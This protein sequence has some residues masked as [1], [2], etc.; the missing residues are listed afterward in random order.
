MSKRITTSISAF[1]EQMTELGDGIEFEEIYT[2]PESGEVREESFLVPNP[3]LTEKF[4][5][6]ALKAASGDDEIAAA[7]LNTP[8]DDQVFARFL[9]AG[10][11]AKL[12]V[13]A[14]RSMQDELGK[15]GAIK[16]PKSESR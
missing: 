9:A 13:A 11:T 14:W 16:L 1:R 10:G 5:D 15:S 2:D 12:V 6:D 8:D 4:V 7:I 3:M